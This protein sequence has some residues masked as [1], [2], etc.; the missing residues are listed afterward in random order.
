MISFKADTNGICLLHVPYGHLD[1]IN[2]YDKSSSGTNLLV[3]ND[4]ILELQ[5]CILTQLLKH[6]GAKYPIR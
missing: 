4:C 5:F 1:P 2:R 6:T 3:D